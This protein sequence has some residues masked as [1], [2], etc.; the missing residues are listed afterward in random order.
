MLSGQ[1]SSSGFSIIKLLAGQQKAAESYCL[2]PL[3]LAEVIGLSVQ[4]FAFA[5]QADKAG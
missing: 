3:S 1:S 4:V 5:G 2:A